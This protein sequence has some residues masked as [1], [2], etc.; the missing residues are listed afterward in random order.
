MPSLRKAKELAVVATCSVNQRNTL[1]LIHAYAADYNSFPDVRAHHKW[2]PAADDPPAYWNW[3][4]SGGPVTGGATILYAK[5]VA[6]TGYATN[7]TFMCTAPRLQTLYENGSDI[8]PSQLRHGANRV[9]TNDP[10]GWPPPDG[11]PWE[12]RQQPYFKIFTTGMTFP[13]H[14]TEPFYGHMNFYY[15][16]LGEYIASFHARPP[17]MIQVSDP[18]TG[19]VSA[20]PALP[21]MT[22]PMLAC[23]T[24]TRYSPS[25][26]GELLTPHGFNPVGWPGSVIGNPLDRNIGFSDGHVKYYKT[27]TTTR[28]RSAP[29]VSIIHVSI[30]H[31]PR[32]GRGGSIPHITGG[33]W[34]SLFLE[35]FIVC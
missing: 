3:G 5:Q 26:D 22:V 1:M 25:G 4:G 6:P 33:G 10:D 20:L 12:V 16:G 34:P 23:P 11:L 32:R 27:Q 18:G 28:E 13:T 7:R 31:W 35:D 15:K 2:N 24:W 17:L 8:F 21:T 14:T 19:K 30:I 29:R 9:D